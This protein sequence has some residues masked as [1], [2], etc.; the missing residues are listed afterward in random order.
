M[1]KQNMNDDGGLFEGRRLRDE[2]ME[3]VLAN[4]SQKWKDQFE[5]AILILASAGIPF[6]VVDVRLICGDPPGHCNAFGAMMGSVIKRKLI[7]PLRE[8][9]VPSSR[10]PAHGRRLTLYVGNEKPNHAHS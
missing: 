8:V 3:R 1:H 6:D 7:I 5:R 9:T 2:G 10:P 4:T